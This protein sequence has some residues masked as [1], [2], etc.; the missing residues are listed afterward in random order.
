MSVFRPARRLDDPDGR[1]WEIY[2]YKVRPPRPAPAAR[3]LGRWLAWLR[4]VARSLRSDVWTIEA[5]CYVPRERYT[6][7]TTREYR[8]HVLARVEG[9]LTRGDVPTRMTYAV[10][11]GWRPG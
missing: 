9:G 1:L 6:W 10:F 8:D 5:V 7:R 11:V 3:R 4:A 2:A